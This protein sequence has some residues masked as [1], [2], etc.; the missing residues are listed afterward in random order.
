MSTLDAEQSAEPYVTTLPDG[1]GGAPRDLVIPHEV[2]LS[3]IGKDR[4]IE[5]GNPRGE[6]GI[7]VEILKLALSPQD[8]DR[9]EA[10]T[11]RQLFDLMDGWYTH[12]GLRPGE[13]NASTT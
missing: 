7:S 6:R 1:K 10:L 4:A 11:D 2:T 8:F 5:R 3:A 9:L 13:S 12:C